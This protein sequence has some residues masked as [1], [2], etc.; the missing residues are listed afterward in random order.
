MKHNLQV[1][2]EGGLKGLQNVVESSRLEKDWT[3][4]IVQEK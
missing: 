3:S 4:F 2:P 1:M